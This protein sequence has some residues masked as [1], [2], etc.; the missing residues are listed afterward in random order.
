V[1]SQPIARIGDKT[2]GH[3]PYLPRPSTGGSSDVFVNGIAVS[4]VGD[5]W[6]PHGGIPPD[7]HSGEVGE[8]VSGSGTVFVNGKPLAR[9]GDTVD[10]ADKIAGGSSDVFAGG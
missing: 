1:S 8:T 2:T 9:I 3:G 5:D 7:V 6:A 10:G 4:R